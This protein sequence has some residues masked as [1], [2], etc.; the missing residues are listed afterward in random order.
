MSAD[1]VEKFLEDAEKL[2]AG[3]NL[4]KITAEVNKLRSWLQKHQYDVLPDGSKGKLLQVLVVYH[5]FFQS[6]QDASQKESFESI[7]SSLLSDYLQLPEGKLL[8]AKDKKKV[9]TWLQSLSAPS[10]AGASLGSDDRYLVQDIDEEC[11]TVTLQAVE[12][13]SVWLEGVIV[14]SNTLFDELLER[15]RSE[16]SDIVVSFDSAHRKVVG[17]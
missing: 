10:D 12:D 6:L 13:D 1:R 4:S 7:V 14:S 2:A 17:F 11:R 9:M 8:V 5:K 16:G 15:F 3:G